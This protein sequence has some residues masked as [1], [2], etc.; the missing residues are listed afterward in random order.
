MSDASMTA[1]TDRW[2]LKY[3]CDEKDEPQFYSSY[4]VF[5]HKLIG[6]FYSGK[7]TAEE[8]PRKFLIDFQS[9]VKGDRPPGQTSANYIRQGAE[10]FK[11]FSP[12]PLNTVAVEKEIR[13]DIDG[14]RF[15]CIVDYIGERDGDL[16]LIDHKSRDMKPRSGR[17]NPT[18]KDEE[19]D[20]MLK[21][22]YLY[23]AAV[24]HEYGAFP[25]YL[26]FNCFRTGVFIQEPFRITAYEDAIRE[27]MKD[28]SRIENEDDFSPYIDY[29]A[30]RSICGVH[31]ECCYYDGR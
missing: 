22:L 10:Y 9:E 30:C 4:G 6:G 21:Q 7:Y 18:R 26:C 3:I 24:R 31:N 14:T 29:F 2:F 25:K 11:D 19:L 8:L 28:I 16:Y 17:K 27:I 23:S 20:E 1:R 15:V 13:F 5:V 12:F